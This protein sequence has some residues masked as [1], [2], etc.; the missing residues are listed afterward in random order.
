M[1]VQTV[2]DRFGRTVTGIWLH[3]GG[4][5]TR[6][7]DRLVGGNIGRSPPFSIQRHASLKFLVNMVGSDLFRTSSFT[8]PAARK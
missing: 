6:P 8:C 5:V 7:D 1:Y 3:D 4:D 2:D